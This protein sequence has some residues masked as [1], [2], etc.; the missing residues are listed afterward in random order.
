MA[1]KKTKFEALN[2]NLEN[3]NKS[4]EYLQWSYNVCKKLDE[5]LSDKT[6]EYLAAYEALTA[7]YGRT[8]DILV[9]SVLRT[10]DIVEYVEAGTVI[11][12]INR[13]EKRGFVETAD[14][15][16]AMK[17]L[18][19]DIVHTYDSNEY[20]EN[21]DDVL[22]L[23]PVLFSVIEKVNVYIKTRFKIS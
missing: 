12:I 3:L 15:L 14:E 18:R 1:K 10:I 11:D 13:A 9:N 17:D 8:V 20:E 6:D 2:E 22:K 21:F 4:K 16:R 5:D 23:T 19:N 7:R